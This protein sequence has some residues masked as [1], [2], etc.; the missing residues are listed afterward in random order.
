MKSITRSLIIFKKPRKMT[1][2]IFLGFLKM[3]KLLVILFIIK[4]YAQ[5]IFPSTILDQS[6]GF[7][8]RTFTNK[9]L[10]VLFCRS[11]S[12]FDQNDTPRSYALLSTDH[13]VQ[14]FANFISKLPPL[15][16]N[17]ILH[18]SMPTYNIIKE[19]SNGGGTSI[20]NRFRLRPF[21]KIVYTEDQML[22]TI[23]FRKTTYIDTNLLNYHSFNG[24]VIKFT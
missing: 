2:V 23:N 19:L 15:V 9:S 22:E 12:P 7:P 16:V 20:F 5:N 14:N 11:Q 4:L 6:Q 3:I 10:M 17:L 1:N 8:S 13:V 18:T 24:N 21:T